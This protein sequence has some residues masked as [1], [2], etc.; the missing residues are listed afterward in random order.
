MLVSD[1][2]DTFDP[3]QKL[4]SPINFSTITAEENRVISLKLQQS[5]IEPTLGNIKNHLVTCLTL[6]LDE[7]PLPER[8]IIIRAGNLWLG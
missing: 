2:I 7:V 8:K 3:A 4:L 5:G 6:A 1:I